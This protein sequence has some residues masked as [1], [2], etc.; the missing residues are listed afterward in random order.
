M[1]Y[2][3]TNIIYFS[4]DGFFHRIPSFNKKII[5]SKQ[6]RKH[7]LFSREGAVNGTRPIDG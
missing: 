3:G 2:L 1:P 7:D 5:R 4:L 6:V